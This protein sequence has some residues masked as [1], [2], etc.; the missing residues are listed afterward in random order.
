MRQ[1]RTAKQ[2]AAELG[3]RPETISRWRR[4][5]DLTRRVF[6]LIRDR[7]ASEIPDIAG[8]LIEKAK[9]GDVAAIRLV[10]NLAFDWA[11][12]ARAE[13]A[14]GVRE[15]TLAELDGDYEPAELPSWIDDQ[16]QDSA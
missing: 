15:V 5:P 4:D 13:V 11:E 2:L 7:L 9:G 12:R 1:P 6:D 3:V 14:V 10:L 16:E 8:A